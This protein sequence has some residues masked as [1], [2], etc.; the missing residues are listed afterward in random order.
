MDSDPGAQS[1]GDVDGPQA[2]GAAPA[3]GGPPA[4]ASSAAPQAKT[5]DPAAPLDGSPPAPPDLSRLFAGLPGAL[6][7]LHHVVDRPLRCVVA[8]PHV[9]SLLGLSPATLCEADD[10]LVAL[11]TH[12]HPDDCQLLVSGVHA[13]LQHRAPWYCAFRVLHPDRGKIWVEG[14]AAADPSDATYWHGV[15]LDM[16]MRVPLEP[17]GPSPMPRDSTLVQHAAEALF[18]HADGGV[19]EQVNAAATQ[20]LG[21]SAQELLGKTPSVFDPN[22]D[23]LDVQLALR[24]RLQRGETFTFETVHVRKDGSVY[25][26]EVRMA[27]FQCG[28][29]MQAVSSVRDLSQHKRNVE[30]LRDSERR[31]HHLT[32]LLPGIVWTTRPDHTLTFVSQQALEYTGHDIFDSEQLMQS[33]HPDDRRR[34]YRD[35]SEAVAQRRPYRSE[36]RIRS[37][38]TGAYRWFLGHSVPLCSEQGEVIEWL[39]LAMDID[40]L[41]RTETALREQRDRFEMLAAV[42]PGVLHTYRLCA[43]GQAEFPYSSP[44]LQK[45]LDL[46]P[47]DLVAL[48]QQP[49]DFIHPDDLARVALSV[50]DSARD[51]TPWHCEYRYRHPRRGEIWLEICSAPV[52]DVDGSTTWHGFMFDVSERVRAAAEVRESEQRYH[53]LADALPQIV[54]T[55]NP[56][57][58]IDFLNARGMEYSGLATDGMLGWDWLDVLHPDDQVAAF[59]NWGEVRRRGIGIEVTLRLRRHDGEY[60]WHVV[61]QTPARNDQGEIFRWIGTCTDIHESK[62]YEEALRHER[63]RFEHLVSAVPGVVFSFLLRPDGHASFPFVGP[64]AADLYGFDP[65]RLAADAASLLERIHPEDLPRARMSM[66]RSARTLG[67]WRTDYRILH[68]KRKE[69][70][71]EGMAIP[72]LQEDGSILWHGVISDITAR[73]QAEAVRHQ[74]T[75]SLQLLSEAAAALLQGRDM[76]QTLRSLFHMAAQY[77]GCELFFHYVMDGDRL[78][79]ADAAAPSDVPCPPPPTLALG[80][81]LCGLCGQGQSELYVSRIQQKDDPRTLSARNWGLRVYLCNPLV[82]GSRVLGTLAFASRRKDRFTDVERGFA[83]TFSRYVALAQL[84]VASEA[85]LR[86]SEER[87]RH[88]M[89]MLPVAV[90]VKVAGKLAFCNP[91]YVR[92]LGATEET[93]LIGRSVFDIVHPDYHPALRARQMQLV[94]DAA[95]L[96]GIELRVVRLDGQSV[97]VYAEVAQ[98]TQAGQLAVMVALSDLTEREAAQAAR[99]RLEEQVRQAHKMEALGRLAGGVAHDFNNLLTVIQGYSDLLLSRAV[100]PAVQTEAL[101][102]IQTASDRAARLTQQLLALSRKAVIE[103]KILDLNAIINDNVQLLRRLIREDIELVTALEPRLWPIKADPGQMDQLILNLVVNARDA[104][105]SGGC[106]RIET[107]NARPTADELG[108]YPEL[109]PGPHVRLVVSDNGVGIDREIQHLIFDPFFTTKP[110]GEGTGL[111]LS[112]VH[113]IVKQSGGHISVHSELGE[114]TTF[115]V[116]LPT[117]PTSVQRRGP[118]PR[119]KPSSHGSET[120]L[121]VEDEANVRKIARISLAMFGYQVLEAS[122]GEEAVRV[123]ERFQGAI[124][125]LITDLVMPGVNGRKLTDLLRQR[126]PSLRVLYMSGYADEAALRPGPTPHADAFI[127][128]PF[129]PQQLAGKVRGL[130]EKTEPSGPAPSQ[131]D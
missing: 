107:H 109:Q 82:D 14:R 9:Q 3:A 22:F 35:R 93:Q 45:L 33:V 62:L 110:L 81:Q 100:S 106:L 98:F 115:Q 83:I 24:E 26:A 56:S 102:G 120:I 65:Q 48:A 129:T 19:I 121:L 87:N 17:P 38:K 32:S 78:R 76:S 86:D 13:A 72:S 55:A 30:A 73:K 57:G 79:L 63:D 7:T 53:Q 44:M 54:W 29:R 74:Q 52:R 104:M 34:L 8:S 116:W 124:D 20:A 41:K 50:M 69:L 94:E 75:L 127:Q 4:A 91:A 90:A 47:G 85:A 5:S 23:S 128:K 18:L 60:R 95:S 28:Q 11:A 113:G 15:L 84:R 122:S 80:E 39:G 88:L 101:T 31:F 1:S 36:F 130:I 77:L 123:S 16:G 42:A 10:A 61:R 118:S 108:Q 111:G 105:P 119:S 89:N 131:R 46:T 40:E 68:E 92:L 27:A 25:P 70:W 12:V 97:P 58:R 112:V 99:S 66:W 114:G 37:Q 49:Q 2:E 96:P 71:V 64:Q 126:R 103:P 6:F 67:V 125:L 59:E 21:Y 43:D 51:L 117:V